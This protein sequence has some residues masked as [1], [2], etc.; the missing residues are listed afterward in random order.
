MYACRKTDTS[1]TNQAP[2][3]LLSFKRKDSN[4]PSGCVFSLPVMEY[5]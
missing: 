4:M 1:Y 2:S 5:I 3:S